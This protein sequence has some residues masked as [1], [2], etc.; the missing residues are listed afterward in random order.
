MLKIYCARC[1][2][3]FNTLFYCL[4]SVGTTFYIILRG[5]VG[6]NKFEKRRDPDAGAA[7]GEPDQ[8]ATVIIKKETV[9]NSETAQRLRQ[10]VRKVMEQLKK[11]RIEEEKERKKLELTTNRLFRQK[12]VSFSSSDSEDEE[13]QA[14]KNN[15]VIQNLGKKG[16]VLATQSTLN[17]SPKREPSLKNLIKSKS[18]GSNM[19]INFK[20]F[21]VSTI[22]Q[23]KIARPMYEVKVLPSGSAFGELALM[24]RKPRAASI[25]CKENSH[26]AV[27]D[28][29]HFDN[30]LSKGA[31]FSIL[32]F[33]M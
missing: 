27:L 9:I 10:I 17:R 20:K 6:V 23:E 26:F 16:S 19:E 25:V 31:F 1:S 33:I 30:I 12:Q 18:R 14:I 15:K 11:E 13:N 4:G 21:I 32:I 22:K 7:V 8:E 29:I 5:S 28:K 2:D 24:E 3:R